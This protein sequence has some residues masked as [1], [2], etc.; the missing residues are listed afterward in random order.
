MYGGMKRDDMLRSPR[1]HGRYTMTLSLL[2]KN[3]PT[4][5][6]PLEPLSIESIF[7]GNH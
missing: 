5:V 7:H 6:K 4:Q 1:D 3:W 2:M